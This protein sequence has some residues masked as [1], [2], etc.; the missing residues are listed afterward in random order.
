MT[1]YSLLS[2]RTKDA[3]T[4]REYSRRRL[5]SSRPFNQWQEPSHSLPYLKFVNLHDAELNSETKP[6]SRGCIAMPSG[7]RRATQAK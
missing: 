7:L 1:A 4:V 2:V 5:T 3:H 6:A